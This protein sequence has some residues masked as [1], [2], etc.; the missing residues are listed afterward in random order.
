M[1]NTNLL[2]VDDDV[3]FAELLSL[4]LESLGYQVYLAHRATLALS[5]LQKH[6]IDVVLTD[7]RMEHMDGLALFNEINKRFSALPVIIMTAH[8][9]IEEA[10][11]ATE[12]GVSGFLTK[13]IDIAALERLLD[14]V[15]E[16][17]SSAEKKVGEFHGLFYESDLMHTLA[18][19]LEAISRSQANILIQGESGTGKEVTAQAIHKASAVSEG[20]FIAINCGAMPANL[21]ES[22][23]FGHQ[24]GAFTGATKDKVGLAQLADNGT[25]F[26]DEIADMPLDLQV[27]LLRVL[28]ERK[29][30]PVGAEFEIPINVRILSASHKDLKKAV[31]AGTF[32][33]DLYYRLN[34][35]S[36]TLP[37]LKERPEDIPLLANHFLAKFA[38]KSFS[39]DAIA[40]LVQYPWPGNI[41]Q[42]HNVVEYAVAL[43]PGKLISLQTIN[44]ALPEETGAPFIGLNEA[45]VQF[46]YEYL[47]KALAIT[48][49]NVAEAAKIAKRNRSDFYKLLKKHNIEPSA[50]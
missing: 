22:E 8:G 3:H 15:L 37:S 18:Y 46:E 34:V 32:R 9:S 29:I 7:L 50:V 44:E 40:K 11:K 13:P 42:L 1:A 48:R 21:L 17:R 10:I 16:R 38:D 49:G 31:E 47:Q 36:I 35:I 2:I 6:A 24:K 20:P 23:L 45:K 28:Q 33:E 5:I 14:G 26:L 19:K 39:R 12:S 41:R 43:T 4:R 27:K 30:R 25:L